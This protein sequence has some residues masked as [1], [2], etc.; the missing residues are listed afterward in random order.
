MRLMIKTNILQYMRL[1]IEI[2][3]GK[4]LLGES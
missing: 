4:I 1:Y 2:L 3:D